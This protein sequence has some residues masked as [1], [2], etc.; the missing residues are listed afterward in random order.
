M[1]SVKGASSDQRAVLH[2]VSQ[3]SILGPWTLSSECLHEI[4]TKYLLRKLRIQKLHYSY[5]LVVYHTLFHDHI[6]YGVLQSMEDQEAT[7][8]IY[9]NTF[10][11]VLDLSLSRAIRTPFP[12]KSFFKG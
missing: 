11:K 8:T 2:G 4:V 1:V 7:V 3:G 12:R 6:R 9:S 5:L 10:W